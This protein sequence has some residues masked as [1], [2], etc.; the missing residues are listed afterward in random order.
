LDSYRLFLTRKVS[1]E[2]VSSADHEA[3]SAL[4]KLFAEGERL[5]WTFRDRNL[6]RHRF[7]EP[8]PVPQPIPAHLVHAAHRSREKLASRLA[9]FGVLGCAFAGLL[10][11]CGSLFAGFDG[12]SGT[13]FGVFAVLSLLS[14]G[15]GMALVAALHVRAKG[16]VERAAEEQM[17]NHQAAYAVW[18]ERGIAHQRAEHQRVSQ[19]AEWGAAHPPPGTRRVDIVGGSLWGWEALLTIF[20]GSLLCT[21]GALTL[22]DFTG[23]AACRELVRL[24]EVTGTSVDVKLL[25]SQL[26]ETNLLAD[27]EP[28]HLV[29]TLIE[30]MY[31]DV[32]TGTRASRAQD[33]RILS[34][35]CTALAPNITMA[36]VA[37]A[38]RVL[39]GEAT[40]TEALTVTERDTIADQLFADEF[41]RQVHA[42]LRR[43]ES[44]IHPLEALGTA[45]ADADLPTLTCLVD[46]SDG[47]S[48]RR[49]LLKDLIVQW[50]IRRVSSL[51]LPTR[52]LVIVG[53]DEVSHL[54]LERLTD[55]CE[56]RDIR[57]VLLFRHLRDSSVQALGG[58]AVGF[59]RLANHEEARHAA[60][61][62]GRQH[63]F[64]LSQ[65]T[66]TLGGND[67]HSV[68]DTVGQHKQRGGGWGPG[69][70]VSNWGVSRSWS[71]TVTRAE[72]TNWSD[73]AAAER[74]YEY[75]VEPR[76][77]QDLPDYALLLVTGQGNGSV[78]QPV[79]CNPEILT[80]PRVLMEPLPDLPLPDP[81]VALIP[82]AGSPTQLTV[83]QPA[84]IGAMAPPPQQLAQGVLHGWG[85]GGGPISA[86]PH[87]V[88]P[89]PH[90]GPPPPPH[91]EPPPSAPHDTS[92]PRVPPHPPQ[93]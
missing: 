72:G 88:P 50:L 91:H 12:S 4:T 71:Q 84:A 80:L 45:A 29:D 82:L 47:R 22:V 76:T 73:A 1:A 39:M 23:E 46:E 43:I 3:S 60:E 7:L 59:M 20:G 49:E 56:R 40:A 36:R 15:A 44:Y 5:G 65:L 70:R 26:A 74:V 68:A 25:P 54:H 81:S 38:L 10:A 11:C 24:A 13:A 93:E 21:R 51:R 85:T 86:P 42:D 52:S 83:G 62:I 31:G 19:F 77:L 90:H 9:I 37:A 69:G 8:P 30:S 34:A 33:D 58:G 53:A 28:R 87:Y 35:V 61:F 78:L 64:A 27:L 2:V 18:R 57:L 75:A 79:E 89:P 17:R 92:Q 6:F 14:G 63:K 67:T 55:L 32:P 66:R 48:A 41:K 16:A